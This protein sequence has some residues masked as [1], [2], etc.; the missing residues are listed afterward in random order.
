[1]QAEMQTIARGLSMGN[2]F[3]T[4][5]ISIP[6]VPQ[7]VPVAKASR[8]PMTNTMAGRNICMLAALFQTKS[9][10]KYL[11]PRESVIAFRLQAKVRIRMAG[12]MALKP[13]GI[14]P[15]MSLKR[16]DRRIRK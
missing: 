5:G 10:T 15:M 11:A 7:E 6:K 4:M 9:R 13:S 1:M 8:Q 12:T 16:M 3:C 2:T 14:Q